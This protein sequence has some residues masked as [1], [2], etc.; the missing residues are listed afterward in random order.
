LLLILILQLI[1]AIVGFTLRGKADK[2]LRTELHES[3]KKYAEGN[4]DAV[5][6]WNRLQQ[7]WSCCG[8]EGW[9]DWNSTTLGSPPDSCCKNSPCPAPQVDKNGYFDQG[10]YQYLRGIFYR[11]SAALGGV[12]LFFFFVEIVGLISAVVLLRD[13]KNNYGSV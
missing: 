7:A 1:A 4:G 2:P 9:H 11:Y 3:L 10:C 8:V 12:S 5:T 13:L 6:E